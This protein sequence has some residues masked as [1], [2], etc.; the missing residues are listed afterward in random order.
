MPEGHTVHRIA[1]R[2]QKDFAGTSLEISSPQGRFT[3]AAILSGRTLTKSEAWGKHLFLHFD[4][5]AIRIHLGIY[6]KWRFT[7]GETPD[8]V[9]QIRARF[10]VP[11]LTADLRGPT[12]CEVVDQQGVRGVQARLGPD[13][14]RPDRRGS[15]RE[16]FVQK[17]TSRKTPVGQQL[18]DQ[19]VIAGIG[20]VYRAELLFRSGINPYTPGNKIPE[21]LAGRIW[22]D[23]LSL[24]P[25]GVRTG[26]ML[27]REGYLKGRPKL[28]DRYYVYKREGLPC[29]DCGHEITLE[30][31][32]TR[33]LYYC[34]RCQK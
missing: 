27:T 10:Q 29:R 4:E 12:A 18:M 9:G 15:E 20:N 26:L 6:G 3:D 34:A 19:A 1:K 21:E 5:L 31:V 25:I 28:D 30:L 16:R 32:A 33:K 7:K 13:P 24:M 23:S 17:L 2:F 11:G 14:L 22:D 8:V